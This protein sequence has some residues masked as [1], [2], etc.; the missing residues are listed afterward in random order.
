MLIMTWVERVRAWFRRARHAVVAFV[1]SDVT[2]YVLGAL[3][4]I[5]ALGVVIHHG[6]DARRRSSA[7]D[8]I[9]VPPDGGQA[10]REIEERLDAAVVLHE[11]QVRV[12]EERV[13]V[14]RVERE[15]QLRDEERVVVSQGRDA[16]ASWLSDFDRTIG[17]GG[18]P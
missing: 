12:I 1:K 2:H 7:D 10:Q 13:V 14:R 16:V 6:C 3:V 5:V 18:A 4:V 9:V 8:T 11:E 15:R 17:D